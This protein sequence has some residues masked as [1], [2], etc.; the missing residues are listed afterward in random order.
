MA[1]STLNEA[2]QRAI[3]QL[4]LLREAQAVRAHYDAT[5]ELQDAAKVAPC[6]NYL[7]LAVCSALN[8]VKPLATSVAQLPKKYEWGGVTY[9][10]VFPAAGMVQI[11]DPTTEASLTEGLIGWVDLTKVAPPAAP[12]N[13]P[14]NQPDQP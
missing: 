12:A 4:T 11:I 1:G 7:W 6:I 5:G 13:K 3:F 14:T 9:R 8:Y 10:L 2:G